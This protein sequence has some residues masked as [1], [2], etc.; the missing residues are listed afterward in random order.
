MKIV[1]FSDYVL[2]LV[3]INKLVIFDYKVVNDY[4]KRFKIWFTEIKN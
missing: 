2:N 3:F 4:N 1:F